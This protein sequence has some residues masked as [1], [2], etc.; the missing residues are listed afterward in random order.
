[1]AMITSYPIKLPSFC[2]SFLNKPTNKIPKMPEIIY[3]IGISDMLTLDR[4]NLLVST[5]KK[6]FATPIK[7]E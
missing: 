5:K 4:K 6:E 7:K 2:C 1:M 3:A